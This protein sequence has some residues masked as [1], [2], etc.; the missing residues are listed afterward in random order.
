MGGTGYACM[1]D[2][3]ENDHPNW[4]YEVVAIRMYIFCDIENELV[5]PPGGSK[6]VLRTFNKHNQEGE[7]V[8]NPKF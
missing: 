1:K 5:L 4:G 2:F 7:S 6:I 8:L 3:M